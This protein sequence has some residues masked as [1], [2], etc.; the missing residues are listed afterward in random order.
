MAI[1]F[2]NFLREL[3]AYCRLHDIKIE[4]FRTSRRLTCHTMKVR[5]SSGKTFFLYV[6]VT[7]SLPTEWSINAKRLEALNQAGRWYLILLIGD[8][9]ESLVLAGPR[10]RERI[11]HPIWPIRLIQGDYRIYYKALRP[12]SF[13]HF[14]SFGDLSSYLLSAAK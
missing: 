7:R 1:D 14:T 8:E 2:P 4:P 13:R 5:L 10:V 11:K 9:G 6:K 12:D 3:N